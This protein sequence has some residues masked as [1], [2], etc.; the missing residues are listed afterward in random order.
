MFEIDGDGLPIL[1]SFWPQGIHQVVRPWARKAMLQRLREIAEWHQ[2]RKQGLAEETCAARGRG[3]PRGIAFGD[4]AVYPI[5][6]GRVWSFAQLVPGGDGRARDI[7]DEWSRDTHVNVENT[8]QLL[9]DAT[10]RAIID[11]GC[12]GATLGLDAVMPLWSYVMPPLLSLYAPFEGT[13]GTFADAIARETPKIVDR[14]WCEIADFEQDGELWLFTWPFRCDAQGAVPKPRASPPEPRGVVDKSGPH[15]DQLQL[16]SMPKKLGGNVRKPAP[17]AAFVPSLNKLDEENYELHEPKPSS[18][19]VAT[20]HS[21]MRSIADPAALSLLIIVW[22]YY[23]FFHQFLFVVTER[24]MM[25]RL[26]PTPSDK[27]KAGALQLARDL[28]LVMGVHSASKYA[29]RFVD[30]VHSE[31]LRSFFAHNRSSFARLPEDTRRTLHWRDQ[32]LPYDAYGS[33]ANLLDIQTYLD[34]PCAC[35]VDNPDTAERSL[36]F[37]RHLYEFIGPIGINLL[38]AEWSKWDLGVDAKWLGVQHAPALGLVLLTRDRALRALQRTRLALRGELAA[39]PYQ[40]LVGL[41]VSLVEACGLDRRMLFFLQGPL[42]RG[43]EL[44]QGEETLVRVHEHNGLA[45]TLR[46]WE[47]QLMFFPGSVMLAAVHRVPPPREARR[48]FLR[49]DAA[50]EGTEHPGLGGVML[51]LWWRFPLKGVLLELPMPIHEQVAYGANFVIYACDL[52]HVPLIASEADA[53]ATPRAVGGHAHVDGMREVADL[54][55]SMPQ[56]QAVARRLEMDHA[57]GAG[58]VFA[59]AVSRGYVRV[60]EMLGAQLGMQMQRRVSSIVT[61]CATVSCARVFARA[62]RARFTFEQLAR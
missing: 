59:D 60:L 12:G 9:A 50:I 15:E 36:A 38:F 58:N 30:T 49:S 13:D 51:S 21:I 10:D 42:R 52:T 14:G 31:F 29:Q 25:G 46:K 37:V 56:Y 16:S 3:R 24:W 2:L 20:N 23:K 32:Y 19:V 28:V 22:D 8:R 41:F 33:H 61:R 47:E 34:D 48:L 7:T 43:G 11:F 55:T 5:A 1:G 40:R 62:A 18:K 26:V 45:R 4:D 39:Y 35:I 44:E 54:I 57:F 17:T 53:S 6:R 27:G